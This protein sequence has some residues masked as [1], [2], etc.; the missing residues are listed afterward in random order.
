MVQFNDLGSNI[1]SNIYQ[2]LDDNS[3]DNFRWTN[4][5]LYKK[6]ESPK[7]ANIEKL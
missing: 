6:F 3:K 7:L 1:L 4:E 5:K 2:N